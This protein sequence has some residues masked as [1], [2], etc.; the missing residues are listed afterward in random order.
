MGFI[1]IQHDIILFF[2]KF[3]IGRLRRTWLIPLAQR[4]L[5]AH[6]QKREVQSMEKRRADALKI[7]SGAGAM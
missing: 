6:G 5:R 1:I 3:C 4:N 7:G 2:I